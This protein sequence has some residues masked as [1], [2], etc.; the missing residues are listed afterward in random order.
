MQG[1]CKLLVSSKDRSDHGK[2]S[3]GLGCFTM[4][5]VPNAT[6]PRLGLPE[7]CANLRSRSQDSEAVA[8][9]VALDGN[10][11]SSQVTRDCGV[12]G[13]ARLQG[14]SLRRSQ[15]CGG[16]W[17]HVAS[18]T[19]RF[20]FS[21]RRPCRGDTAAVVLCD[22]VIGAPASMFRWPSAHVS[23]PGGIIDTR[24]P[25]ARST[26]W[27]PTLSDDLSPMPPDD[28]SPPLNDRRPPSSMNHPSRLGSHLL[29]HEDP[30]EGCV[31][32]DVEDG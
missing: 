8:H 16:M 32:S 3:S 17:W 11:L 2:R 14:G 15:S 7:A 23:S 12:S 19:R 4:R 22:Q 10:G 31:P 28:S 29:V 1:K 13:L 5:T 26:L 9:A 20:L 30:N 25:S 21:N 6:S 27:D 24:C 18:S